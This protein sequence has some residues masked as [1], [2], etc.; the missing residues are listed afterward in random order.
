MVVVALCQIRK[1]MYTCGGP[2]FEQ[3]VRK[4]VELFM[5]PFGKMFL[6]VQ[7]SSGGAL[8]KF[9]PT[10]RGHSGQNVH[11]LESR[12]RAPQSLAC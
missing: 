10:S 4:M 1:C 6:V 8:W 7:G 5:S 11:G 12:A 3:H 9:L 2:M